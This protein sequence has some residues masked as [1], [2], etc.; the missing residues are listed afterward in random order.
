MNLLILGSF[1]C[2]L[3]TSYCSRWRLKSPVS[4]VFAQ[5]LI[6]TH[7]KENIKALRQWPL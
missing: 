3:E 5:L 2:I 4:P 6:R 7:I 1:G